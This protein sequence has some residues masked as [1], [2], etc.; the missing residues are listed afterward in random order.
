MNIEFISVS[1][2]GARNVTAQAIANC[3]N[4]GYRDAFAGERP[5]PPAWDT[6]PAWSN[7]YAEGYKLGQEAAKKM[8]RAHVKQGELL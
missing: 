7:A 1:D 2:K 8:R 6:I 4:A 5:A 3:R